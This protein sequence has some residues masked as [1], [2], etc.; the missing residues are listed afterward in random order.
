MKENVKWAKLFAILMLIF[1]VLSGPLEAFAQD[2]SSASDVEELVS[3]S[4]NSSSNDDADENASSESEEE[5]SFPQAQ[6]LNTNI[7]GTP[8]ALHN[9]VRSAIV[10]DYNNARE[11][12]KDEDGNYVLREGSLFGFE[13]QFDLAD[14]D[15]N[16]NNGDY[17]EY[18]IPAPLTVQ[19]GS[20]DLIDSP[21]GIAV[22]VAEVTSNGHGQGGSVH[23]S[24]QN[25]EKYLEAKKA[26]TAYGVR[27][28]FFVQFKSDTI[29]TPVT[30]RLKDKGSAAGVDIML[31]VNPRGPV[32]DNGP[33]LS[34]ENFNKLWGVMIEDP[35]ES[36]ALGTTGNYVHPWRVRLN[37][38]LGKYNKYVV[39]DEI[40]QGSGDMQFI[41]ESFRLLS[42]KKINQN[43][44]LDDGYELEEGSDYSITFSDNYTKFKMTIFNPSGKPFILDYKTTAPGD[45]STV[46]NVVSVQGDDK[47]LPNNA[48]NN[49]MKEEVRRRSSL[50][51]GGAIQL[52]VA[53]RIVINKVDA[54]TKKPLAGAVFKVTDP[55]GNEFRLAPTGTDGSTISDKIKDTLAA[56]GTFKIQEETAPAG[57][58]L[59][60]DVTEVTVTETGV[61]RTIE[62][63]KRSTEFKATKVWAGDQDASKRP[64]VKFQLKRDG[65]NYGDAKD[66]P[67]AGGVVTWSNLPYYQDGKTDPSVYT[68]EET[69]V[70]GT[71]YEVAYSDQT[72]TST[73]VT[74]TYRSTEFKATKVWAGDQD[75]TKRPAVKFQLKRDG[76]NYGDAKDVPQAGGEV[77]W[78]NLP[79]YQD[80]KTD[81]SVYTVEETGVEGTGYDVAYSDQTATSATVTNTYR[82]TEFK[83]TKVWA[84]DQ[85]VSKRPAA[86]FQLKRDG[87]NYGDAKDVPQAGG[88]VTWSN[89][90]YYQDG[91]TEPSV[92]TVEETGVEGTG[93][94]VA[95]SNQTA[96]SATVTN[97][98]RTTEFKVTKVWAG[99]QDAS[100]RPSVKFQLKRDGASYG[101]AKDVPKEGGL[102]TW[103]NLPYYQDGKTDPSVYTV[104]E[105]TETP[106]G[107]EVTY[108]SDANGSVTVTNTFKT[109]GFVASKVW[110]GD[111]DPSV[112]PQAQF[113]LY[114]DGVAYGQPQ[115]V[116]TVDGQVAWTNLP[117]YQEGKNEASVYTV[118]EVQAV[119]SPYAATYADQTA[120]TVT[121]TNTL[122][123][124]TTSFTVNKQWRGFGADMKRP[125]AKFQLKRDG[126]A[127]GELRDVPKEDGQVVWTDLPLYQDG[128]TTPSVYTVDELDP[129]NEGG[130]EWKVEDLTATSAKIINYNTANEKPPTSPTPSGKRELPKTGEQDTILTGLAGLSLLLA[131][132]YV[133]SPVRRRN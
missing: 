128:T 80:G 20:F 63:K 62:N 53:Y 23:I 55:D 3:S 10:W 8:K 19:A 7:N 74:N 68:V 115:A 90:P 22:G 61:I 25:L 129:T 50:T 1:S 2:V 106:N 47:P 35:W 91:K 13:M 124:K 30:I 117:Y 83:A 4:V 97:T 17:F 100:K 52:N 116:P 48:V 32:T 59:S 5:A 9:A 21:T 69:G 70:E 105:L 98:Y 79:Y 27:G 82:S 57:Y 96:T 111:K 133:I 123:N 114:R 131:A 60:N 15:Y 112:R 84:G 66:V 126:Q 102:V 14:Y 40:S 28:S 16:L 107:Y 88:E 93:Y 109:T 132:T 118:Q 81:P 56:K 77:S 24:I 12:T 73:T 75:A 121:V 120:S 99:D 38:S 18:E 122:Q 6:A 44:G 54:E 72:A 110:K 89:L 26:D 87:A 37:A 11:A 64:S 113:Q 78:S 125:N 49:S 29:K 36:V 34:G 92:Y 58:E 76:V 65:A 43:W 71:G 39:Y 108:T 85:D 42:G 46:G 31:K 95:Y 127:Y 103:T 45:G 86:K 101:E 94:D 119:D 33:Y 104:E 51:E 130:Y 67:K 41:P